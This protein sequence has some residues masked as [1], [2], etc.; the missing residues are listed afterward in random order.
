M[1][2]L[3]RQYSY[4]QKDIAETTPQELSATSTHGERMSITIGVTTWVIFRYHSHPH[5]HAFSS[6]VDVS[7]QARYI[8]FLYY[9]GDIFIFQ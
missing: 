7:T 2:L 6:H 8:G 9:G 4:G 5:I 3:L 1:G